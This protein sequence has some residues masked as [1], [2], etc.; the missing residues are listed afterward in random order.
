M[1]TELGGLDDQPRA[2]APGTDLHSNSP[3]LPEGLHLVKVGVPDLP[4]L[5]IGV[6][7]IMAEDRSFSTNVANFCH[8]QT[9]TQIFI[10]LTQ[11]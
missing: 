3:S 5:V 1:R 4:R 2:E 7:H 9:S 10:R 6:A 8:V 11:L